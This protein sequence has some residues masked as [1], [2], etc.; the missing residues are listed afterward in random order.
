MKVFFILLVFIYP[1]VSNA[2][3]DVKSSPHY[4]GF[5][6]GATSGIGFSYQYKPKRLGIQLTGV[7]VF[8]DR[9]N[10]YSLGGSLLL[11]VA[12][13]GKNEFITYMSMDKFSLTKK[14][15]DYNDSGELIRVK[16]KP[17]EMIN[18]GTGMGFK[19]HHFESFATQIQLG[20]GFYQLNKS[21]SVLPSFEY[22]LFYHF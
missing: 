4:I 6:F 1:F 7:P 22:S 15:F 21:I 5:Q 20:V 9:Y 14:H 8:L 17:D 16:E 18:F 3:N 19:R 10:F 2:Q 11:T 13:E 12:S